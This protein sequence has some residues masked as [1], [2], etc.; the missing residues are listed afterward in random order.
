MAKVKP[1]DKITLLSVVFLVL[2]GFLIF[3]SA[4]LGLLAREG[5]QF[6]QTASSQFLIGVVGG[7]IALFIASY[8]PYRWYKKFSLYIFALSV[9]VTLMVFLPVIG[10]ELNG[11]KR[12]LDLGFITFQPAELLKIGYVLYL[13]VW[14]SARDTK[15]SLAKIIPFGIISG[16][17]AGIL[18]LQPDTG[19]FA[20][21]AAAGGAM[22][23]A[24]GAKIRDIA[25]IV[26]AGIFVLTLVIS[27]RPYAQDR[28]KTFFNPSVDSQGAGWQTNQ[29]LYAVGS[30]GMFGRGF[31]QSVQKFIYLPEPTSDS[32]FAVYSE[33]F[34]FLG[35]VV[36]IFAFMLFALRGLWIAA[37]APD[38]FGGLIAV[39]IVILI[40]SQSFLNIGSMINIFPITGLPLIFVSHGGSALFMALFSVGILLNISRARRIS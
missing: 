4:S 28:I 19:T 37:R 30:G 33:E 6:S 40:M 7:F 12:W 3:M 14:L 10:L 5:P 31:G 8:I 15:K 13:A 17:T 11:A 1:F 23:V 29:S 38:M 18:L 32:I 20:V 26:L 35:G 39:G 24:S 25:I 2:G 22:F 27:V 9:L 34:G 36:L 21:I 16:I